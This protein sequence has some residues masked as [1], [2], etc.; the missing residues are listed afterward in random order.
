MQPDHTS[1]SNAN[2]QQCISLQEFMAEK[3]EVKHRID[4]MELENEKNS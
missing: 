1:S 2:K 3:K 4:Q